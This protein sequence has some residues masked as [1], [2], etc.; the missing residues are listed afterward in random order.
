MFHVKNYIKVH[1]NKQKNISWQHENLSLLLNLDFWLSCLPLQDICGGA[2]GHQYRVDSSDQSV[3]GQRPLRLHPGRLQLPPAS[4]LRRLPLV[5]LL[6]ETEREG[7]LPLWYFIRKENI[8]WC[9]NKV[10]R[11]CENFFFGKYRV[12]FLCLSG[13]K[14]VCMLDILDHLWNVI[15]FA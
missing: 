12:W 4:H 6:A 8:K 15:M 9:Q 7:N 2:G 13:E 14:G 10:T 5:H 3:S 11:K 1:H